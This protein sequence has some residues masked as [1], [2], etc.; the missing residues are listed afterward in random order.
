MIR[1]VETRIHVRDAWN[2]WHGAEVRADDVMDVHWSHP[3]GAPHT[4]LQGYV[5]CSRI[6]GHI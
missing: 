5:L 6:R 1:D 2:G 3:A 4:L